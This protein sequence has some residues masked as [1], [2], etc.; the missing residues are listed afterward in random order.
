MDQAEALP[1]PAAVGTNLDPPTERGYGARL[2]E[3][4]GDGAQM[5]IFSAYSLNTTRKSKK[6]RRKMREG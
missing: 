4:S 5:E 3:L 6:K 1:L 2:A